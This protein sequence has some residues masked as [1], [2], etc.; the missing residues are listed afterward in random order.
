MVAAIPSGVLRASIAFA[1]SLAISS[2]V[3]FVPFFP[4]FPFFPFPFPASVV[5]GAPANTCP[6]SGALGG[7]TTPGISCAPGTS[8]TTFATCPTGNPSGGPACPVKPG[9]NGLPLVRFLDF[10]D[11]IF[12][13][14]I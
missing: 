4:F 11:I 2:G 6:S 7:P 9:V 10:I 5:V 12:L 14:F 8:P 13:K 3:F 1:L